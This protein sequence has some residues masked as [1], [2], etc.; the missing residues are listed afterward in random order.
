MA[1]NAINHAV[2]ADNAKGIGVGA[3]EPEQSAPQVESTS[4]LSI[5]DLPMASAD[6]Y[7]ARNREPQPD[8][9]NGLIGESKITVLG[10]DYGVGKSPLIADLVLHIT[11]G[12]EWCGRKVEK[13]PVIHFDFETPA[14][15]YKSD[16]ENGATRLGCPLPVVPDMLQPF[17]LHDSIEEPST[18]RLVE[19]LGSTEKCLA[20]V[21]EELQNKPSA[22][23]ILDPVELFAPVDKLKGKEIVEFYQLVRKL[24]GACP[25]ASILCTFNLRKWD[26]K[27]AR[28][29]NLLSDPREWLQEVSGANE[30]MTRS[31]TRLGIDF[32]DD[33]HLVRVINGIQRGEPFDPLLIQPAGD[34]E[35]GFELCPPEKFNVNDVFTSNQIAYWGKL[36]ASFT[37]NE[38]LRAGVPR[39]SLYRL[40]H[41]AMSFGLLRAED[42][43]WTKVVHQNGP[44]GKLEP[45]N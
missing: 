45:V 33:E 14:A 21:K 39:S 41:K 13:R 2:L 9:V 43:K 37:F 27:K 42:E 6:S 29:A 40:I 44:P 22:V 34:P 17:F 24:F 10:G 28:K 38:G 18:K 1:A 20:L 15:K 32:F 26:A 25:H 30:I 7:F 35:S 31:D 12:L 16:L 19:A 3:W 4:E 8:I 5:H 23:I 11:N 36:P